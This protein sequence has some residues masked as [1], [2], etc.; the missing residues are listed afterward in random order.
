MSTNE[1]PVLQQFHDMLTKMKSYEEA[2]GLMQWDLRTGAPRKGA[3]QR[4]HAIGALSA[5]LFSLSVSP[6]MGNCLDELEQP[7]VFESLSQADRKMV[8]D[9]RKEYNR[10]RLIPP[11]LHQEYVVLTSH[12]ET[13]W[14]DAKKNGD[15][16]S[17][18]PYLRDIVA[19]TQQFIDYWGV[20]DTRY[21]T[22]LD[23]YEPDMTVAK[24]DSIFGQLRDQLVPLVQSV[25][26]SGKQPAADF[27]FQE[28]PIEGQKAI[29][30]YLL[31]EIGYDF[32]AGR[33]DESVHP[34]AIGLNPGDV[35]ITTHYKTH[36]MADAIFSSL[37]EGGHALY[38]QN[39]SGKYAGTPL[40]SGT[41]MGIHESQS[42][43]WEN[44][45]GRSRAFWSRYYGQVQQ[46]F[47]SQ[48]GQV[49]GEMVYRAVNRVEPSL[50]RIEADEVTYNLHI[51]IR[52]EIEKMLFNEGLSVDD[53]PDVWN[54]KY[55]SYLGVRPKHAGE[56]V[57]QDV[58]WSGG[59]FGY[60]P[61]YSL[62]NMYAAQFMHALR[63]G[64]PDVEDRIARGELLAIKE[65]LTERI[66]QHGKL[67]M[68]A[69]IV[70]QVTGEALNP[71]YLVDYLSAKMK[72]VY[73]L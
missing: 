52:Y 51:I 35:R 49:T 7:G 37:H 24:L 21:D 2:L 62:G 30:H 19:K 12:A 13:L 29:S 61:S 45:I 67:L 44:L 41:S 68:P 70:M 36:D 25:Q 57:L 65:W 32:D 46:T 63:Q 53:L 5:D 11:K 73:S 33:L 58:H 54:D 59:G 69:E 34:F 1:H 16:E 72:D 28:F 48:L 42:R 18:K 20:R 26:A 14:E 6:E 8:K 40:A 23:A 56:G 15:Y 50:I 66:Y 55:E 47:P 3:E 10:S 17:F 60:F 9:A 39:I 27:L 43:F 22:L 31:K 4:A 71:Q 38:E 64:M